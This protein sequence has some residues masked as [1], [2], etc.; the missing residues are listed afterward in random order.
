MTAL[1][2]AYAECANWRKDGKGCLRVIIDADLQIRRCCAK[3][4]C[5]LS[6]PGERCLY[7][8]ECVAPMAASIEEPSRRLDFEGAVRDYRLAAKLPCAAERPCPTCGRAM[9]PRQRFC[10]VCARGR[11]KM[12]TRLAVQ[13]HRVGCKQL[14][15]NGPLKN[16]SPDG[17]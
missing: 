16:K 4:K 12:S 1:Q 14:R 9:E 15:A 2:I 17:V 6:T 5:V 8:E 7:F 11:R 13:R 3:P 10:E